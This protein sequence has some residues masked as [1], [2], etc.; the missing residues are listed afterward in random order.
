MRRAMSRNSSRIAGASMKNS[1][2]GYAAPRS[3]W[4]MKVVIAPCLVAIST[5]CSI[6]ACSSDEFGGLDILILEDGIGVVD[7]AGQLLG[8]AGGQAVDGLGDIFDRL[9]AVLVGLVDQ[10]V[11]GHAWRV[12]QSRRD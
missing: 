4:A 6:M 8:I 3:G 9:H 5:V 2:A 11:H 10:P 12:D 1:T 7:R